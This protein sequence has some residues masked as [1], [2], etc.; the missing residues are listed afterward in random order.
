MVIEAG[1]WRS[2]VWPQQL[3]QQISFHF[4]LITIADIITIHTYYYCRCLWG[5]LHTYHYCRCLWGLPG[6]LLRWFGQSRRCSSLC[7]SG[8]SLDSQPTLCQVIDILI[9]NFNLF[10]FMKNIS[11]F[12]D[13][14]VY[15]PDVSRHVVSDYIMNNKP[16]ENW[17]HVS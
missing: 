13:G 16:E 6:H 9:N 8:G 17:T 2:R 14:R 7:C 15:S 12:P 3:H 5:L 4:T 10:M 1:W 11:L